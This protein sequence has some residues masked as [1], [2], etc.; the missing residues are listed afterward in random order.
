MTKVH[1]TAGI[2]GTLFGIAFTG[3]GLNQYDVIHRMLSLRNFDPFLIMASAMATALPVLWLLE[4]RAWATPLGGRLHLRRWPV[5]RGHVTGGV[6]FGIGWAL[7][8][9]CP[10]TASTTLGAGS[11]LGLVLI[12]GMGLGFG[13]RDLTTARTKHSRPRSFAVRRSGHYAPEALLPPL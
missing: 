12:A 7:T 3:A 5:D 6:I 10:G 13:L 4:R 9:A 2:F 11:L 1:L 8:G